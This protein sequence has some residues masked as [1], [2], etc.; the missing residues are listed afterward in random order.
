MGGVRMNC[1]PRANICHT[2][3]VVVNPRGGRIRVPPGRRSAG[4][5]GFQPLAAITVPTSVSMNIAAAVSTG[6]I[7]DKIMI[8]G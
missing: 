3:G 2:E 6:D 5:F 4:I 7:S 1:K 8:G